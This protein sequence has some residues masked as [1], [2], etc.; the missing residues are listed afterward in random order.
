ML[1]MIQVFEASC[2][3]SSIQTM[4]SGMFF[5]VGGAQIEIL[6]NKENLVV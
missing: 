5:N 6:K 2:D 1:Q 4:G 3:L